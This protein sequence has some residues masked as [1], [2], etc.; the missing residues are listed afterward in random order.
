MFAILL[1]L[2]LAQSPCSPEEGTVVCSCKQGSATACEALRQTNAELADKLESAAAAVTAAAAVAKAE[3]MREA[4][5]VARGE[6][7]SAPASPEPPDCKG[8]LHHIISRPIAKALE[9]HET[10]RGYYKPRD[11]RLVTRAVDEQS[12]CGYQDWHR[13]VDERVRNWLRDNG[14]A[15]PDQFEAFL[16]KL[17]SEPAMRARFPHGF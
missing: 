11:P 16:R 13:D 7:D 2:L 5:E 14:H 12:H 1:V 15:T 10:L 9:K 3:E 17:Y 6:A 8:Q 4:A